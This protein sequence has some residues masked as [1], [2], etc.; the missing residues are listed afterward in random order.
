LP[1]SSGGTIADRL[2]LGIAV[3]IIVVMDR[4]ATRES[5]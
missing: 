2:I 3:L 4:V 1:S 5:R